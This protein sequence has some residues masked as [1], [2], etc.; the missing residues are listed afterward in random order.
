MAKQRPLILIG[1]VTDFDQDRGHQGIGEHGEHALLDATVR[2][3]MEL[4]H[5]V[6]NHLR[7]HGRPML[8]IERL[9][10][11]QDESEV[12]LRVRVNLLPPGTK[13]RILDRRD[14]PLV[15]VSRFRQEIGLESAR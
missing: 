13:R 1:Q 11:T 14:P 3:W 12:G 15:I 10:L 2:A 7:E 9:Q 5:L 8:M 4:G 6:L